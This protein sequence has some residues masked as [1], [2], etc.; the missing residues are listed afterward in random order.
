MITTDSQMLLREP[1][2]AQ[3]IVWLTKQFAH[4]SDV[5]KQQLPVWAER[6]GIN[7]A[8]FHIAELKQLALPAAAVLAVLLQHVNQRYNPAP[9]MSLR[10]QPCN[11]RRCTNVFVV[12]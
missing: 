9:C 6:M 8:V 5:I 11:A 7:P 12:T 2:P 1:L 10:C 3:K 4:Y